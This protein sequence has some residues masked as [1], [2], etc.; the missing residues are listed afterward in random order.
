MKTSSDRGGPVRTLAAL[1]GFAAMAG[2][3]G[4]NE[5]TVEAA[6]NASPLVREAAVAVQARFPGQLWSNVREK[7]GIRERA[8]CAEIAGQQVIYRSERKVVM[9]QGDFGPEWA[10]LNENWCVNT[11]YG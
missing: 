1:V 6:R 10:T 5:P 8:V 11:P 2:C 9:A 3:S 4:A 7:A